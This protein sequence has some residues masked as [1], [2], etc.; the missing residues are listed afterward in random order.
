MKILTGTLALDKKRAAEVAERCVSFNAFTLVHTDEELKSWGDRMCLLETLGFTV[1]KHELTDAKRLPETIDSWT[2]V[3]RSGEM[4]LPVDGLVITYDDT[5]YAATGSVT[6]HHATN[7][8]MAFKWQDTVAE[9]V[10]DHVEWS[11]AAS[12]ISPVAVF[13]MVRLEGTEVRRASLCNISEMKRLGIGAPRK[14]KLK[15][16]KA[17]MIIPKCI[18]ADAQG[19]EFDIP[20]HCPVCGAPTRIQISE[21]TGTETLKCTNEECSA[22]HIQK[23]ARFVSKSGMDIDGLSEKTLIKFMNEGFVSDFADIYEIAKHKETIVNMEGFGEKS[24]QNMIASIEKRRNVDPVHFIYALCIPMIGLDAAKR[25]I[26][27]FGTKETF[28]RIQAGIGFEEVEGIGP[29]KS[30]SIIT[31]YENGK[32]RLL[33][34]KLL[35]KVTVTNVEPTGEQGGTCSGLT[36]V[37]TGD[38]HIYKNRSEFTSFVEA[39]GGKVTGSVSAKTNYLVNNDNTSASSKNKKAQQLGIP[40]P[41]EEEFIEKFGISL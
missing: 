30:N 31:W 24:Y 10:L 11:C 8:G 21:K 23:Y 32:N 40:I 15:I 14:T 39:Q 6:G 9:T 7:A 17:N 26:A 22:K 33:F 12:T 34:Q 4:K 41:T 2:Q 37:I 38:V 19:T 20:I 25:I 35:E 13:D 27:A 1:V 3:V 18:E 29:E 36:F 16:I 28:R 5:D